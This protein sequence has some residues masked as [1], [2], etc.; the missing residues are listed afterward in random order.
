MVIVFEAKN[1]PGTKSTLIFFDFV[2]FG[3]SYLVLNDVD[4]H[5]LSSWKPIITQ[6]GKSQ[7]VWMHEWNSVGRKSRFGS[8]VRFH[9]LYHFPQVKVLHAFSLVNR[10]FGNVRVN[11]H[12]LRPE[13]HQLPTFIYKL[14]LSG[15]HTQDLWVSSRQCYQQNLRGLID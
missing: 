8:F 4:F 10:F 15:I 9:F 12:Q 7:E 2:T 3:V 5:I 13:P 6:L 1:F 11:T 14:A